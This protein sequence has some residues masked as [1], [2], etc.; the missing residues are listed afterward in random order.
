MFIDNAFEALS[1]VTLTFIVFSDFFVGT[2][3]AIY[4]DAYQKWY[5]EYENVVWLPPRQLF[6]VVWVALYVLIDTS[7]YVF[8]KN[9]YPVIPEG[10]YVV[11][12][13]V[14]L[15]IINMMIAKSWSTVFVVKRYTRVACL[16]CFLLV[17]TGV[18]ILVP[19]GLNQRWIEFGTFIPYVVWCAFAFYLNAQVMRAE[20][21]QH[22]PHHKHHHH[23]V[24]DMGAQANV[25]LAPF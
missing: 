17:G 13:V 7:I 15:F 16:M 3:M 20:W 18:G 24:V 10:T 21:K 11:P 23:Q 2:S 19:F 14:V 9:M 1:F 25:E 5:D 8:F 6:P 4:D 22:K 12:T